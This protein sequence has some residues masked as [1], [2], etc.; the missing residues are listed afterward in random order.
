MFL[1]VMHYLYARQHLYVIYD[2]E[3]EARRVFIDSYLEDV[4]RQA[5]VFNQTVCVQTLQS[6][7]VLPDD[8]TILMLSG[9][10]ALAAAGPDRLNCVGPNSSFLVLTDINSG[11]RDA[12]FGANVV[13]LCMLM[14]SL[15]YTAQTRAIASL[16]TRQ[17][18]T[19]VSPYIY[20]LFDCLLNLAKFSETRV[21]LTISNFVTFNVTLPSV[22]FYAY[23]SNKYLCPKVRSP[24][25]CRYSLCY[26]RQQLL[27][28]PALYLARFLG[29]TPLFPDSYGSLY[30][31]G[32]QRN[33]T[34]F[35]MEQNRFL[36]M[37]QGG[38]GLVMEKFDVVDV[39]LSAAG[40]QPPSLL[41]PVQTGQTQLMGVQ[42]ARDP[43]SGVPLY[44]ERLQIYSGPV[45]MS[46]T[47]GKV[48]EQYE[49]S[50]A[51]RT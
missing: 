35:V 46:Q 51:C 10:A 37:V 18:L 25:F 30:Q 48:A 8:S 9:N 3:D 40:P 49:V 17:Q 15:D 5:A 43:D 13:P 23:L 20:A 42:L 47:M 21:S 6:T 26:V 24:C 50:P 33:A 39:D 45:P 32:F 31:F 16:F 34:S 44:L 36:R 41:P 29:G 38:G 12:Y 11:A 14:Y 2:H 4:R 28:D 22:P 19:T 7:M 1:F 27:Q